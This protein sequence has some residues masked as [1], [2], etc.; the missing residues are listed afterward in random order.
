MAWAHHISCQAVIA[1][2]P[3]REAKNYARA[4]YSQFTGNGN[5]SIYI[6]LPLLWPDDPQMNT[7]PWETWNSIRMLCEHHPS[8][9]V[10]LEVTCDMPDDDTLAQ[11]VCEPV[12]L[13]ILPTSGPSPCHPHPTPPN[14]TL[15]A[16]HFG[17]MAIP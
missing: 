16:L 14:P 3:Q 11:W 13:V 12:R 9:F 1:P 10:A 15:L 2:V 6:H 17:F 5:S 8:L 4:I 7:D